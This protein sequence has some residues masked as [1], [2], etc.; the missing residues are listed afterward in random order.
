[1]VS[2]W[3]CRPNQATPMV[4]RATSGTVGKG[5]KFESQHWTFSKKKIFVLFWPVVLFSIFLFLFRPPLFLSSDPVHF[6]CSCVAHTPPRLTKLRGSVPHIPPL[7]PAPSPSDR[8]MCAPPL[9]CLSCTQFLFLFLLQALFL[10][11]A[12][13][14]L[15]PKPPQDTQQVPLEPP[16]HA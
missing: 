9:Q 2:R 14:P 12:S 10:R 8:T 5:S 1:M 11:V 4:Q 15:C 3:P 16:Y 13:L 6:F 7:P